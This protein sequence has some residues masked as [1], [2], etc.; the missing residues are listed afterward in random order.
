MTFKHVK[1]HQISAAKT[2][3]ANYK[4]KLGNSITASLQKNKILE[5]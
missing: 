1:H 5:V 2:K 4:T 3:P